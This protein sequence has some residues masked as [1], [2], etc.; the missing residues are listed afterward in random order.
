MPHELQ[1]KP[2]SK[3]WFVS[4]VGRG[5]GSWLRYWRESLYAG[6]E[7]HDFLLYALVT[8]LIIAATILTLSGVKIHDLDLS[9]PAP[10]TALVIFELSL[11]T[12]ILLYLPYKRHK[13]EATQQEE[14]KAKLKAAHE[15]EISFKD[16]HIQGLLVKIQDMS[17]QLA[18]KSAADKLVNDR[19][20][21]KEL[22][23]QYLIALHIRLRTAKEISKYDFEG[24][25]KDK[26]WSESLNLFAATESCLRQRLTESEA[27]LFSTA[28][29][30]Q[31]REVPG[32]SS[33][34]LD[35]LWHV[36]CIAAKRDALHKIIERL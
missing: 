2:V 13:S 22:L 12:W 36:N 23:G 9:D 31:I 35:W 1:V 18:E 19:L 30:E 32:D 14:E 4:K 27:A 6:Q 26:E 24:D 3:V 34:K 8:M 33:K 16:S 21:A 11:I 20:V 15:S 25:V 28:Q 29:S 17:K 5:F 7:T 10:H